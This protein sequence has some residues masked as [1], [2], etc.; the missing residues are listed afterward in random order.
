MS[1]SRTGSYQTLGHY[2]D[3]N[4]MPAWL[5]SG[6]GKT[7]ECTELAA[8]VVKAFSM[9]NAERCFGGWKTWRGPGLSSGSTSG[10]AVL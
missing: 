3:G 6:G 9:Q 4:A 2:N 1:P 8:S 7:S 5:T 10:Q